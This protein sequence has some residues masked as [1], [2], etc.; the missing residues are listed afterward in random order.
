MPGLFD[1]DPFRLDPLKLATSLRPRQEWRQQASPEETESFGKWAAN[2]ALTG[3]GAVLKVID[4]PRR[5]LAH[6]VNALAGGAPLSE[7]ASGA[8]INQ[9][10]FGL[11][12]D[13]SWKSWGA[14][15]GTEILTDP[16]SYMTFGGAALTKAGKAAKGQGLL[17][18]MTRAQKVKGFD[19]AEDAL[20]ATH[21]P[22]AIEH[23]RRQGT[24]VAPAGS[25]IAAGAPLSGLARV[26]IPGVG[27]I[28]LGTGRVG[29]AVAPVLDK[30]GDL[31]K[32]KVPG[33]KTLSANFDTSAGRAI[34]E[35]TQRGMRK[36]GTPAKEEAAR[37]GSQQVYRTT[38]QLNELKAAGIPEEAIVRGARM[39]A[40]NVTPS[41]AMPGVI[42]PRV[43]ALGRERAARSAARIA[44][45][46]KAGLPRPR[47]ADPFIE[48]GETR[49]GQAHAP[50]GPQMRGGNLF[51]TTSRSDVGRKKWAHG[52]PGGTEMIDKWSMNPLLAGPNRDLAIMANP[53]LPA[54]YHRRAILR[55]M[56]VQARTQGVRL[57]DK[58][59]HK[60]DSSG[61]V[62]TET[63]THEQQ[64]KKKAGQVSRRLAR[65]DPASGPLYSRNLAGDV[66]VAEAGHGKGMA[67]ARAFY[68][69]VS[70]VAR[71]L[72]P[73]DVPVSELIRQIGKG[74]AFKGMRLKT[75]ADPTRIEG[76]LVEMH[77]ALAK[78]GMGPTEPVVEKLLTAI[79]SAPTP[80]AQQKAIRQSLKYLKGEVGKYGVT[81]EHA[82][83]VLHSY[84]AWRAPEEAIRPIKAFDDF[85][86]FFRNMAYSI[87]LPSHVRNAIGGE[88]QAAA[89]TGLGG[90]RRGLALR[91]LSDTA[92]AADVA[93]A[94]PGLPAGLSDEQARQWVK[95]QAYANA[96]IGKGMNPAETSPGAVP[97]LIP[98]LPLS[99]GFSNPVTG[100]AKGALELGKGL[101]GTALHPIETLTHPLRSFFGP[102]APLEQV[103]VLGGTK[104]FPLLEAGRRLGTDVENYL[105][106]SQ[107]LGQT[108][109][110]VDPA[111]AGR[112]V[113]RTHFNY[114]PS[115]LTPFE[116]KVMRRAV[117]FYRFARA[118]LPLQLETLATRP[119]VIAPQLRLAAARPDQF[120]PGYLAPGVAI[121]TGPEQGGQQQFVSQLGIPVEE[122][123]E[124]LKLAP[125]DPMQTVRNVAMAYGSGLNPLLKGPLEQLINRQ[126][127]TGRQLTDLRPQGTVGGISGWLDPEQQHRG[128]AQFAAQALANT[129][130]A[131]VLTMLDKMADPRKANW[132]KALNLLTGVRISDVDMGKSRAIETRRMLENLLQ[133]SPQVSWVHEPYVRPGDQ[134][135]LTPEVMDQLQVFRRLQSNSQIAAQKRRREAV[136][137]P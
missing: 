35:I 96:A 18:G 69:T 53:N 23:L 117:P 6:G 3:L 31:I 62:T 80:A 100:M 29:Q 89:Q 82:G 42:D 133:N 105:R 5:L 130:M 52:V 10:L 90:S 21:A 58:V 20:K 39:G 114:G 54:D 93:R 111:E 61:K 63:L 109:R 75:F 110:G 14:G 120:V 22:E 119:G 107:Y 60:M 56:L 17:R 74:Q 108:A 76:A 123:F 124:R 122:A 47:L 9:R 129:P 73:G 81:P 55:D 26:G 84:S 12:T 25:G 65:H 41:A 11:P 85:T 71:K 33:M 4:T 36:Y 125:G 46:Q 97:G 28:A 91:T 95:G 30:L 92:T 132:A 102:G 94:H 16:L 103:G 66:E 24:T 50:G 134:P 48:Y 104:N 136:N 15:L 112:E 19:Y 7:E 98:P 27:G 70:D 37:V 72:Q 116:S 45:G 115:G 106:L 57:P 83:Q 67:S 44:E 99:G 137:V 51:P 101:A 121:P 64:L 77:K 2:N 127:F 13:N 87:W 38:E 43:T 78:A 1:L 118:N 49:Q 32:Y 128:A 126:L 88:V 8:E 79:Q 59:V 34:D 40:E 131:R 113:L 68:G 135:H 86:N